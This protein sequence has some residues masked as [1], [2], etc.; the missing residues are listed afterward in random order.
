MPPANRPGI[1]THHT[2]FVRRQLAYTP[3]F[4]MHAVKIFFLSPSPSPSLSSLCRP[5]FRP[6]YP[7]EIAGQEKYQ[8]V[9]E[10][11]AE[12]RCCVQE[13]DH[14]PEATPALSQ[15]PASRFE[16]KRTRALRHCKA[17][18]MMS[19]TS[20]KSSCFECACDS[21]AQTARRGRF[22][23]H[24]GQSR[25]QEKNRWYC[26]TRV[27][28]QKPKSKAHPDCIISSSSKPM[29]PCVLSAVSSPI[30]IS[31]RDRELGRS[32]VEG[33]LLSRCDHAWSCPSL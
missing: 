30:S 8:P 6:P 12:A 1:S 15:I 4:L 11:A 27:A 7:V 16:Q 20:G 18:I 17:F 22:T 2:L 5:P 26:S 29:S 9:F 14:T 32:G 24:N 31:A 3:L 25:G 10:G 19:T 21:G 13:D 23:A 28:N 33:R